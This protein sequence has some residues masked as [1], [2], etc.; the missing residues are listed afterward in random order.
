MTQD[1][2]L[3]EA[4]GTEDTRLIVVTLFHPL[5]GGGADNSIPDVF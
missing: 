4:A 5:E 1:I 2:K 3:A